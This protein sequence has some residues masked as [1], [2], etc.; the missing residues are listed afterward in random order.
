MDRNL[1]KKRLQLNVIN[2]LVVVYKNQIGVH[3]HDLEF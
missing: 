2:F 1:I 3:K